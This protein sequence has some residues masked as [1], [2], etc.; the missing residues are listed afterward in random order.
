MKQQVQPPK[1]LPNLGK[2][3]GHMVVLGDVTFKNERVRAKP[4]GQFLDVLLQSL[5]LIGEREFRTRL[6][7][8]LRDGPRDGTLVG[9][10][11]DNSEF[12]RKRRH[13]R[14]LFAGRM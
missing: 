9:D 8:G 3:P 6:V 14:F 5:A 7:P 1:L 12:S 10:P 13:N 11:K 4:P 2:N